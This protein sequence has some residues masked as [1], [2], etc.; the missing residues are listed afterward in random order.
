M[1]KPQDPRDFRGAFKKG[2][3][4]FGRS[5]NSGYAFDDVDMHWF[6]DVDEFEV[7]E[8]IKRHGSIETLTHADV[9][10]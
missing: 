9:F 7:V 3:G 2:S 10:K 8:E 1:R 6:A 5:V 4:G